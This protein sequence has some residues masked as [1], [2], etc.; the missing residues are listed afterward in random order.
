MS[1]NKNNII[2][3]IGWYSIVLAL[4][5]IAG[6]LFLPDEI[7][8]FM[9]LPMCLMYLFGFIGAVLSG[10]FFSGSGDEY[11]GDDGE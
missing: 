3:R 10:S 7:L 5:G 9:V 2:E 4:L 6:G 8:F 1:F 11:G